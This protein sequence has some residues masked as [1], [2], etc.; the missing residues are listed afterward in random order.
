VFILSPVALSTH[1]ADGPF[2]EEFKTMKMFLE[3]EF[4]SS[5]RVLHL[6][7]RELLRIS[8]NRSLVFRESSEIIMC[9]HCVDK[10]ILEGGSNSHQL[11]IGTIP[12]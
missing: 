9:V 11:N 8:N 3:K 2:R 7:D 5:S 10:A 6:G 1:S 12:R 4:M